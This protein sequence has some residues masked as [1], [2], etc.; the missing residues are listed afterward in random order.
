MASSPASPHSHSA[1]SGAPQQ[2]VDLR[3]RRTWA[4][5]TVA[6]AAGSLLVF[7]MSLPAFRADFIGEN[8]VSLGLYRTAGGDFIDAIFS[9]SAGIFFRPVLRALLILSDL[10]LPMRPISGHIRNFV[11]T[12]I[13]LA[14][15]Y[16]LLIQFVD[17]RFARVA[18]FS[19]L[20]I[21]KVH[22]TTIGYMNVIDPMVML[23]LLVSAILATN[24]F[25]DDG[26]P[27]HYWTAVLCCGLSVFSKDYGL[28]AA[29]VLIAFL[30]VNRGRLPARSRHGWLMLA[31]PFGVLVV[32]YLVVR[33]F[34]VGLP[35]MNNAVYAPRL[36]FDSAVR[37][38]VNLS[39]TACNLAFLNRSAYGEG[40]LWAFLAE[41]ITGVTLSP[42]WADAPFYAGFLILLS[43]TV[44]RLRKQPRLLV[45]PVVVVCSYLG[46]T[47]LTRNQQ[48]YY[49]YESIAAAGLVIALA[50]A[51]ATKRF[52][53]V[54]GCALVVIAAHGVYSNYTSRYFWQDAA[55]LVSRA[56]G[57]VIEANAGKSVESV[58]LV[59]DSKEFVHW[60]L[61]AGPL[62]P[63]L[64]GRPGLRVRVIRPEEF[65]RARHSD[66][67][68]LVFDVDRNF[69]KI[70]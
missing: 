64:M 67:S 65:E 25:L 40:G 38:L 44:F 35:D 11:L 42:R 36:S 45:L 16:R 13:A 55:R 46:P 48:I 28:A 51:G 34:A 12:I 47:L 24:R 6:T 50:L 7:V 61:A 29:P 1:R 70:E 37:K 43:V 27:L 68:N 32:L 19:F 23:I 58:T 57:P 9:P 54:W 15:F 5:T 53:I 22:L 33:Y 60:A 41:R 20:A 49:N 59:T 8:F 4:E 10:M 39:A 14:L 30:I 52:V 17:S 69:V 2:D 18:G 63:E 56:R 62:I 3:S 31:A 21:S 26:R 66:E